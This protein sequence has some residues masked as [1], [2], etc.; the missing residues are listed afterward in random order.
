[1]SAVQAR[2]RKAWS[3][4]ARRIVT[5]PAARRPYGTLCSDAFGLHAYRLRPPIVDPSR[6]RGWRCYAAEATIDLDRGASARRGRHGLG[7]PCRLGGGT[8]LWLVE[9]ERPDSTIRSW[10]DGLWWSVTTLTTVGYGDHV[11]VTRRVG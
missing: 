1:M 7:R 3:S 5:A 2:A 11:P 6:E 9:G 4:S 10:G 8:A